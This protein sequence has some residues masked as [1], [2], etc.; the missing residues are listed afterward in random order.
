MAQTKRK[1]RTKHR[2]NAAGIVETRGRTGRPPTPADRK[3]AARQSR[4]DRYAK[5]PSWRSAATRALI[6]TL[7]FVAV[8]VFLMGQPVTS[9][10]A[11]GGFML[12][13]YVPLGFYTDT[14]FYRRRQAKLGQ[15]G[16]AKPR[17]RGRK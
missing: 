15:G 16:Q 14:Y 2:G 12:L 17:E 6:A 3:T 4:M 9:A 13:L 7:L 1:R 8:V 10:I 5:P 11:L